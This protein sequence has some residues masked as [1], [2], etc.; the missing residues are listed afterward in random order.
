M[1]NPCTGDTLG[2]RCTPVNGGPHLR[3][4][5]HAT[6]CTSHPAR[7]QHHTRR[8]RLT[9]VP[10]CV[11]PPRDAVCRIAHALCRPEAVAHPRLERAPPRHRSAAYAT[12]VDG[13]HGGRVRRGGGQRQRDAT[14]LVTRQDDLAQACRRRQPSTGGADYNDSGSRVLRAGSR[15]AT[16]FTSTP[17][18]DACAWASPG[19][20]L[21]RHRLM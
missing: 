19:C 13:H 2:A 15:R 14:A 20:A 10:P 21:T 3:R 18:A 7:W 1:M 4:P 11:S 12:V 6:C 17:S 9:V 8:S 5:T 16:Q